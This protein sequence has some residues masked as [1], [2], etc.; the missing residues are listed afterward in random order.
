M[1]KVNFQVTVS[2]HKYIL[3]I[4]SYYY[5]LGTKKNPLKLRAKQLAIDFIH[6]RIFCSSESSEWLKTNVI[7]HVPSPCVQVPCISL[8]GMTYEQHFNGVTNLQY[9]L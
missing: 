1:I 2:Y 7:P 5:M 8:H 9:G 4:F 3:T 6:M